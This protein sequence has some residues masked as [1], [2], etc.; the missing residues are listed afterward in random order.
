MLWLCCALFGFVLFYLH[1]T[2]AERESMSTEA[3][4]REELERGR[5]QAFDEAQLRA[6]LQEESAARLKQVGLEKVGP[7]V[8]G[9]SARVP[10]KCC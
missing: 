7:F 5:K 4:L 3:R 2:G 9:L 10:L 8:E 1:R 6:K